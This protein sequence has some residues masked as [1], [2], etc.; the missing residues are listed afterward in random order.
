[1]VCLDLLTI[2]YHQ[3]KTVLY[4][5]GI[6]W[7]VLKTVLVWQQ[8]N[9]ESSKEKI[10]GFGLQYFHNQVSCHTSILTPSKHPT[11]VKGVNLSCFEVLFLL[12]NMIRHIFPGHKNSLFIEIIIFDLFYDELLTLKRKSTY[13]L[14]LIKIID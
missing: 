5:V 14:T 8:N 12:S 9:A 6:N 10:M 11:K 7:V 1:M 13:F 4:G 2:L 3:N